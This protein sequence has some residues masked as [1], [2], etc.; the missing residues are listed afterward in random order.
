MKKKKY[1]IDPKL[2][3]MFSANAAFVAIMLT[4]NFM[5]FREMETIF[6]LIN[7]VGLMLIV[8]PVV[9]YHYSKYRRSK[10]IEENFP[11]FLRDFVEA[12]RGGMNVQQAMASLKKNDY[13]ELTP[14]VRKM[15]AQLDWGIPIE[16][17]FMNFAEE[18]GSPFIKRI[19]FSVI[20]SHRYGGSLTD[21]L[22]ALR[23]TSIQVDRLRTER[24]VYLSTQISSGYIVFF[25]F[26]GVT[27][28]LSRFLIPSLS[29][30]QVSSL[31]G[32]AA[33]VQTEVYKT[34]FRNLIVMQGFFAGLAVGKMA[35]GA[36][37]SGIKH[38]L[39]MVI[40]GLLAFTLFA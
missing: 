37:V 7:I 14:L 1:K 38:S 29:Q 30:T 23:N 39:I 6:T 35:E 28:A 13:K 9:I 19:V 3:M 16:K 2:L 34:T 18:A 8:M 17:V 31:T 5:F 24:R 11:L 40:I 27:L 4:L 21:T 15:A 33:P 22:E 32:Q 25:V 36:M 20:E 26:L 10:S 12:L